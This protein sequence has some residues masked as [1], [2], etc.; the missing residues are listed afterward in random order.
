VQQIIAGALDED[1]ETALGHHLGVSARYLRRLFNEHL[2]VTPT[3]LASSRRAH[4]ARRLLDDSDL[5]ITQVALA[6]GFGSVRHFNRAMR[7]VFRASPRDLRERRRRHDRLVADG[8]LTIRVPF[9]PPYDWDATLRFFAA[10][11]ILG[12]ESVHEGTY[13]RTIV[14]DGDPGLLELEAGGPDHL[15]LHTHLPYWEGL[16]RVVQRTSRMLGIDTDTAAGE[17]LLAT[18]SLLGPLIQRQTGLRIPRAWGP[19]EMGVQA[20]ISQR[21]DLAAT[22]EALAAIARFHGTHVPGLL[23]GLKYAFPSAATLADTNLAACQLP[24]AVTASIKEFASAVATNAVQ[25]D[26][27]ASLDE[28]VSSLTTVAAVDASTAQMIALRLGYH[29]AFPHADPH[30]LRGLQRVAAP[31]GS[32]QETAERWRPWRALAA[33][34]LVHAEAADATTHPSPALFDGDVDLPRYC[35]AEGEHFGH[36]TSQ[37][38][39]D[40]VVGA[41][42]PPGLRVVPVDDEGASASPV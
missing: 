7:D 17:A 31:T 33:A 32:A 10:R 18:D 24:A 20:V 40:R 4:F 26:G 29:D 34:H 36:A 15:L 37:Q 13:R 11:A 19:F 6:S 9:E 5:T 3:Q 1:T 42:D 12:V 16:I 30:V 2:G 21:L 23:H 35:L 38:V 8:G 28:L 22:R 27:A 39:S 25:F 41:R 14:L